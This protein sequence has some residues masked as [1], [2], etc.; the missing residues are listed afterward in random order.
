MGEYLETWS[1][2]WDFPQF[3]HE[4]WARLGYPKCVESLLRVW[5]WVRKAA[6][7]KVGLSL[8]LG[9]QLQL[10]WS[11]PRGWSPNKVRKMSKAKVHSPR[12]SYWGPEDHFRSHMATGYFNRGWQLSDN[13]ALKLS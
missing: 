2:A 4:P 3:T 12:M 1:E 8:V 6:K 13:T 11:S 7:G 10:C 5:K 9:R